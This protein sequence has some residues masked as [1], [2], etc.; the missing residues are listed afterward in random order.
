[1]SNAIENTAFVMYNALKQIRKAKKHPKLLNN[2]ESVLEDHLE[3]LRKEYERSLMIGGESIEQRDLL[4]DAYDR[5]KQL[6]QSACVSHREQTDEIYDLR[7]KFDEAILALGNTA[8][9]AEQATAKLDSQTQTI[10]ALH[11]VIKDQQASLASL[12]GHLEIQRKER[13]NDQ[14][15]VHKEIMAAEEVADGWREG[16][17]AQ[18]V[19]NQERQKVIVSQRKTIETLTFE[20]DSA[21]KQVQ[22]LRFLGFFPRK[23]TPA[24]SLAK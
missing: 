18:F 9:N 5:Q 21:R 11:A 4:R 3:A 24:K 23:S 1:M 17:D 8:W 10:D 6:T 13:N 19:Q 7:K 14:A 15:R 22:R 20:L 12:Q 2:F 16:Y